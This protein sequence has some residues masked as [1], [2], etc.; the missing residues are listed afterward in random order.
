MIL[1]ETGTTYL[2]EIRSDKLPGIAFE[3]TV[4]GYAEVRERPRNKECVEDRFE[5]LRRQL[6][7]HAKYKWTWRIRRV[8]K[9]GLTIRDEK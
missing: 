3:T 2:R 1:T 5:S 4:G 8:R 7:W 6:A 9:Q